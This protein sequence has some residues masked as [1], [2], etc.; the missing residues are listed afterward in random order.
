MKLRQGQPIVAE[1]WLTAFTEIARLSGA[2][3]PSA[4]AERA[5]EIFADYP[6]TPDN[7]RAIVDWIERDRK[8][9]LG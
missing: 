2:Q 8:E 9:A 6:V 1:A 5:M 4:V 7:T 3:I